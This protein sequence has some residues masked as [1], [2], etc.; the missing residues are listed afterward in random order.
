MQ[1]GLDTNTN[2]STNTSTN[3]PN[4]CLINSRWPVTSV[5]PVIS[6]PQV[7]N[8]ILWSRD[9]Y[10]KME[11]F[12]WLSLKRGTDRAR[13]LAARRE[14]KAVQ[15]KCVSCSCIYCR[16]I[17]CAT[18]LFI[19]SAATRSSWC[20]N[21]GTLLHCATFVLHCATLCYT[22]PN[23]RTRQGEQEW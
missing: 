13:E 3:I 17:D 7:E 15:A 18:L 12:E 19:V 21:G 4:N 9:F 6:H 23:G 20:L 16:S 22:R 5:Q 1:I 14:A 11:I 2:T 8:T 10:Q